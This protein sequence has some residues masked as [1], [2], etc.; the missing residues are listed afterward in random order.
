MSRS[1][2]RFSTYT[3]VYGVGAPLSGHISTYFLSEKNPNNISTAIE[4]IAHLNSP[5]GV[6]TP[7]VIYYCEI[8][9][10]IIAW[11]F[12]TSTQSFLLRDY[13]ILWHRDAVIFHPPTM[14]VRLSNSMLAVSLNIYRSSLNA[15]QSH[16]YH[17]KLHL[18]WAPLSS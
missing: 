15:F 14:G 9:Y 10:D 7:V 13:H 18:R 12:K 5:K 16:P 4:W 17:V 6:P 8:K 3:C 1:K 11:Q 2:C